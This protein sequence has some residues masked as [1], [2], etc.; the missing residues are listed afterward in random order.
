VHVVRLDDESFIM[1]HCCIL[2]TF[3]AMLSNSR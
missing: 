2:R 1:E 3:N